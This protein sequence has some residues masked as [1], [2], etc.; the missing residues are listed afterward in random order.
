MWGYSNSPLVVGGNVIVWAG[1]EGSKGLLAYHAQNGEPAWTVPAGKNS[2]SSPQLATLGGVEQ[3][4]VLSDHGVT[5]TDPATGKILWEHLLANDGLYMPVAQPQAI[6]DKLL[7]IPH[8]NGISLIEVTRDADHWSTKKRWESKSLKLTLNDFVV[9][10]GS[11]YGF[12]DGIFCCVDLET[13]KPPLEARPLRARPGAAAG[14]S[15]N[16]V[17]DVRNWRRGVAGG[18]PGEVGRTR[19]V[20]S[21]RRQ[22]LES[23]RDRSRPFVCPQRRGNGL[24]RSQPAGDAV[25]KMRGVR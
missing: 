10:D 19:S 7:L 22:D 4:L 20:Q 23:S 2:Y 13:G 8:P 21:H 16:A 18:E 5:A 12:D 14:R 17:R 9:A 25:E 3:L 11:V 24:L 1:K 6:D 15:K